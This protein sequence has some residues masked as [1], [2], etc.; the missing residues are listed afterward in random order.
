MIH[1]K[2]TSTTIMTEQT[3]LPT[4]EPSRADFIKERADRQSK[5]NRLA[6]TAIKTRDLSKHINLKEYERVLC[7]VNLISDQ[8]LDECDKNTLLTTVLA[9]RCAINSSRQGTKD[10][11]L[12]ISTCNTI[13][14]K[15]G[16]MIEN[17]SSTAFRPTKDGK[18]LTKAEYS[19]QL[20]D[21]TIHKNDCLKSFDARI[22]GKITGWIFAKVAIGLGGHQDNVFEEAHTFCEWVIKYGNKEEI[23]IVLIDTDLT[24]N[25]N[26][27]KQKYEN[28][29]NIIIG[30]HVSIQQYFIDNY[31]NK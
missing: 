18:L 3:T 8:L 10:E 22:T 5:N 9:G 16:V 29:P 6:E 31:Y 15:C 1:F 12:Q 17:L 26:E 27:L 30:D 13:S 20:A 25:Y 7:E 19:K 21:K 4:I 28:Q 23:Y 24:T 11:E 2:C 14:S